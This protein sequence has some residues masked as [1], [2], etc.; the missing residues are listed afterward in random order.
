MMEALM[1]RLFVAIDLPA[2][3]T[4]ELVRIQPRPM[5]GLRVAEPGQMHLTLH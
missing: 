3:A 2:A 5:A 1:L 4:A